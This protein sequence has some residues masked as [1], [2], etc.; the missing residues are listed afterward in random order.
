MIMFTVGQMLCGLR[1]EDL[2]K[3]PEETIQALCK[4]MGITETD[5]LYEMTVQG[6]KWWEIN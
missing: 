2:K 6:K 1:L 5:S 4:W 3:K